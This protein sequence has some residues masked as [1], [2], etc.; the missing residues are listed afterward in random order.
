[1]GRLMMVRQSIPLPEEKKPLSH[2]VTRTGTGGL[3]SRGSRRRKVRVPELPTNKFLEDD[4]DDDDHMNN[5][6]TTTNNESPRRLPFGRFLNRFYRG[7]DLAKLLL[8]SAVNGV[9]ELT[10]S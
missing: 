9:V 6:N 1:M 8:A 10:F 2:V 5:T 7:Q 3:G 4:D